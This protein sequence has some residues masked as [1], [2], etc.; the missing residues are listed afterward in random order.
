MMKETEKEDLARRGEKET[1]PRLHP[2][3]YEIGDIALFDFIMG[4]PEPEQPDFEHFLYGFK[5]YHHVNKHGTYCSPKS[6]GPGN[7]NSISE[8]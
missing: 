3:N 6:Q 7:T 5:A 4:L 2:D 8:T 1:D